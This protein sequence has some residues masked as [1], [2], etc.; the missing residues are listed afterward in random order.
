MPP[1]YFPE[2]AN[3][4]KKLDRISSGF[5]VSIRLFTNLTGL[6]YEHF[7][8]LDYFTTHSLA[9]KLKVSQANYPP[10]IN[11]NGTVKSALK[12]VHKSHILPAM[13]RASRAHF[14]I[15]YIHLPPLV[16]KKRRA[17]HRE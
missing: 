12:Q 3:I 6:R 4:S 13:P 11:I 7:P 5:N 15:M 17:A 10:Q 9:Y 14:H 8:C 2:Y 1:S 16:G